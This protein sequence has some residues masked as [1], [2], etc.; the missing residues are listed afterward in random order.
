MIEE[1]IHKYFIIIFASPFY[2]TFC[3][4]VIKCKTHSLSL[5]V[6]VKVQNAKFIH[7]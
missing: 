1:I 3:L 4:V 5:Y 2:Q 6:N 7:R